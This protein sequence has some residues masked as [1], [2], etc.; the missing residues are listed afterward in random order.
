VYLCYTRS[1]TYYGAITD[2]DVFAGS[3]SSFYTPYEYTVIYRDLNKGA[4]GK[5]IYLGF[6]SS[7]PSN[8]ILGFYVIQGSSRY[9]YAPYGWTRISQDCSEGAGG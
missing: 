6:Q 7:G 1:T 4:G 2:I 5:F 8:P 3:S 9:T